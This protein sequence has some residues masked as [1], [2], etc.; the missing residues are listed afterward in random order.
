MHELV[1]ETVYPESHVGWQV[2]PLAREPV[3]SPTPPFVGAADA[4]H[5]FG[6]QVAAIRFPAVHELVPETVYPESHVGWQVD[7][8]AREPVQSPTPPFVGAADA[9]HGFGEQVAAIRFPAVHELVPETVYPE[10]H[11]GWQVDPLAREPVQSPTPPFVGAADASHGFGEQVAAIRFPAVHELVP[12]TVYPESHVGWQVDPL[13]REPVQSPT[14]PFVG[15]AD[16]SHGLR[17]QVALVSTRSKHDD[18]PETVYPESH[19]GWQVDPLASVSV[20]VPTAPLTMRTLASHAFSLRTQAVG[21]PSVARVELAYDVNSLHAEWELSWPQFVYLASQAV[22]SLNMFSMSVTCAVFHDPISWLNAVAPS[23]IF[24]MSRD[25]RGIPR[26][27]VLVEGGGFSEHVPHVR[28]LRGIPRRDIR[29][30]LTLVSEQLRHVRHLRHVPGLHFVSPSWSAICGGTTRHAI[31]G[32]DIEAVV[33][34]GLELAS[35]KEGGGE[36]ARHACESQHGGQNRHRGPRF[37]RRSPAPA[38]ASEPRGHGSRQPELASREDAFK[39]PA[40]E[41]P[42]QAE[43]WSGSLATRVRVIRRS[44]RAARRYEHLWRHT[45]RIRLR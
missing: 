11:V 14:P 3:Q 10:S 27:D 9:S 16:A 19:V 26:S 38:S 43:C 5:G 28:D 33:H 2:D 40:S 31:I 4:S 23:N 22:A 13:A 25:L 36:R 15:A 37:P 17:E 29:V 45:R 35:A 24:H 6:E 21:G 44:H 39:S 1:P 32:G 12:E 7:P 8:L 34:R 20:Q 41:K 18:V 42:A 30:E